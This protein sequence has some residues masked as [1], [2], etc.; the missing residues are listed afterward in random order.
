MSQVPDINQVSSAQSQGL[1]PNGNADQSG[2]LAQDDQKEA[3][4]N[5]LREVR[6]QAGAGGASSEL[7]SFI[8]FLEGILGQKAPDGNDHQKIE[9]LTNKIKERSP[10]EQIGLLKEISSGFSSKEGTN[11]VSTVKSLTKDVISALKESAKQGKNVATTLV[12][13]KSSLDRQTSATDLISGNNKFIDT[14]DSGIQGIAKKPFEKSL[15]FMQNF[16]DHQQGFFEESAFKIS[17]FAGTSDKSKAA[18]RLMREA[19]N[20]WEGEKGF[21]S[22]LKGAGKSRDN[23]A[24]LHTALRDL[25]TLELQMGSRFDAD[26]ANVEKGSS[27]KSNRTD[28]SSSI[29]EKKSEI[30]SLHSNLA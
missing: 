16:A 7:K 22:E 4:S 24:Q 23:E 2:Y 18:Y 26:F 12:D 27:D 15:G 11:I 13:N 8:E 10:Q 14:Q 25:F 5:R 20:F 9:F 17:E 3:L 29:S 28:L 19:D 1:A 21:L 6:G 30:R